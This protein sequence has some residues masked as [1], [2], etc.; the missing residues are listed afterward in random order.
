MKALRTEDYLYVEYKTGEHEL[1]D[2]RKDPYELHNEYTSAPSDLKQRLEGQLD[3]L[4]QCQGA[5]CRAAEGG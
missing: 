1:Y 4:G 3:A 2:L 5:G